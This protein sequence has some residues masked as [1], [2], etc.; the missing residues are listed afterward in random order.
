MQREEYAKAVL[1]ARVEYVYAAD[2]TS[3]TEYHRKVWAEDGTLSDWKDEYYYADGSL[4]KKHYGSVGGWEETYEFREDGTEKLEIDI[5]PAGTKVYEYVLSDD[6]SYEIRQWHD[7]GLLAVYR[8]S[9]AEGLHSL[10]EQYLDNGI[11]YV[12][13][14]NGPDG[15]VHYRTYDSG[16]G[17]L[18]FETLVKDGIYHDRY[19]EEGRLVVD[20]RYHAL[21]DGGYDVYLGNTVWEYFTE[22]GVKKIRISEDDEKGTTISQKVVDDDGKIGYPED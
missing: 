22:G 11:L 6:G 10:Y 3:R 14:E 15:F 17:L 5:N 2:G 16:T 9:D 18:R 21:A 13:N 12:R 8:Y 1:T 4:K 20:R 7:N 19:Y